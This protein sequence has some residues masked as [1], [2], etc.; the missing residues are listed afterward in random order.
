MDIPFLKEVVI[1]TNGVKLRDMRENCLLLS[2]SL[3]NDDI[4][5]KSIAPILSSLNF[6]DKFSFPLNACS[7]D[8]DCT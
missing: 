7:I 1:P 4:P 5:N 2:L 8:N 3:A 6:H